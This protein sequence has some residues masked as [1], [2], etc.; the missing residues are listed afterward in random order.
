MGD[1]RGAVTIVTSKE[2]ILPPSKETMAKLQVKHPPR[3]RS[4][5]TRAPAPDVNGNLGHFWLSKEDVKHGLR[6]FKKGA[7]AGPDGL[8]PQHL[9]DMTGQA[10]G[11]TGNRLLETLVD[12]LNLCVLPGKVNEKTQA[13]FY[14][15]NLTAL[16]KPDGGVRPIVAGLVFRRL[17][18]KCVMRKLR[19]FCEK[20]FR[21][22]QMGVGTPKGCEAAVHA[23]RAYVE[24]ESVQDQVLLKIDFK[25]S[26]NVSANRHIQKRQ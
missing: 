8:R 6:S 26:I 3:N 21:P 23:T 15:G 1:V 12:F 4:E 5:L 11:E 13:T 22:L 19:S 10:L 2:A 25:N 14:S 16:M 18:A 17:A 24:S 20:E 9:L 7:A